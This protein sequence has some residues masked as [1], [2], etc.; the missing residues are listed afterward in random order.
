MRGPKRLLFA[1]KIG[2]SPSK[3]T[4]PCM[5][6]IKF[7]RGFVAY[8]KDPMLRRAVRLFVVFCLA[9]WHSWNCFMIFCFGGLLVVATQSH[10]ETTKHNLKDIQKHTP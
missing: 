4:L 8:Q 6:F 7:G 2:P 10:G 9:K 1:T 3:L 5:N